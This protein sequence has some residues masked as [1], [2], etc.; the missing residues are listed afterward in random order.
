MGAPDFLAPGWW[1]LELVILL[2]P[3]LCVLSRDKP[4]PVA[5]ALCL[6]FLHFGLTGI[7]YTG[8]WIIIAIPTMARL[9]C[10]IP[11]IESLKPWL[12]RNTSR[13]FR[14]RFAAG[15][16]TVTSLPSIAFA[17][18]FLG[19]SAWLPVVTDHNPERMPTKA[20]AYLLETSAGERVFHSPNWGGFLTW[21]GWD[22]Q[23]RFQTWIDDRLEVHG[24]EHLADYYSIVNAEVDW[25]EK[26][27]KYGITVLCLPADSR[28]VGHARLTPNWAEDYSDT[29][30]VIFRR[31]GIP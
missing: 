18:G 6:V 1:I 7:R 30:V 13:E 11:L 22:L 14:A 2:F 9:S 25:Q 27:Q 21:H 28:L 16:R 31:A 24:R 4:S 5:L 12:T 23:P 26:L 19:V 8:L 15:S 20:L 3:L 17:V 10:Q 29:Y